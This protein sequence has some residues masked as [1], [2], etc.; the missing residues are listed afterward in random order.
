MKKIYNEMLKFLSEE[1]IYLNEPMSKHTSFKIGG[2]ADIFIK[3]RNID[4]LKKVVNLA[5]ENSIQTTV[6][7]NGSNLLVKD[8]RN[9]RNCYKTRF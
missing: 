8:R 5:K 2:M 7:G 3:P 4:E 6:I 1:Q 9:K